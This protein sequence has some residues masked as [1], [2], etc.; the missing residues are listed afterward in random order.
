MV[1]TL[2]GK[3]RRLN[4]RWVRTYFT[5]SKTQKQLR[6]LKVKSFLS[7]TKTVE[8]FR[9]ISTFDWLLVIDLTARRVVVVE[10]EHAR[11]L[12]QEGADGQMIALQVETSR[13]GLYR[14]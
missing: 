14:V 8:D 10:D 9:Q 5:K 11:S 13:W 12:Y 7:E 1:M 2:S 4:L 3:I 6:S